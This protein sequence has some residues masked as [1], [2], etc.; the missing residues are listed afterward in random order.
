M[1]QM[2]FMML[3]LAALTLG[4][5]AC[6][7]DDDNDSN[8]NKER[9]EGDKKVIDLNNLSDEDKLKLDQQGA[10][11]SIIAALTGENNLD[12][13]L[14]G[15]TYEPT[16]GTVLDK[17]N[18]FVRSYQSET[19]DE[20]EAAFRSF[21]S[22]DARFIT[23]TAD[24]LSISLRNLPLLADGG[25]LTLG[26]LTFHRG[27][28]SQRMGYVDVEIPAMPHL[29]R[30]DYI[31]QSGFPQNAGTAYTKGM[32]VYYDGTQYAKGYYLCVQGGDTYRGT[33][34]HL[35][36]NEESGQTKNLDGDSDGCWYPV[37]KDQGMPSTYEDVMAYVSY[38][39]KNT[40]ECT[41]IKNFLR[42]NASKKPSHS[43]RIVD[44]FPQHFGEYGDNGDGVVWRSSD[45]RPAHITYDSYFGEYRVVPA[46]NWRHCKYARIENWCTGTG[47]VSNKECKY[48]SDSDF[49]D[50]V[51]NGGWNFCMNV[52]RF[53]DDKIQDA[54]VEYNAMRDK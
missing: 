41:K 29:Q 3:L 4:T 51:W 2:K 42:G 19:V 43:E 6:S 54:N 39:S 28:G 10:I 15:G 24:G 12:P 22:D 40:K 44:I 50:E 45:G 11:L 18:P 7:D 20:A 46:Y 21:V 33:L 13:L 53:Y 23:T 47:Q 9:M 16:Y 48:T 37:N 31:P 36:V 30:I 52:I 34:V 26:T 5:A 32:V 35:N 27:D 38:L 25:T 49:R 14:D 1:K 8:Q 17:S